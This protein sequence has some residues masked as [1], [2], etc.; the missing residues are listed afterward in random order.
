[1]LNLF[2]FQFYDQFLKEVTLKDGDKFK[3]DVKKW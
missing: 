3:V 1:M 2:I